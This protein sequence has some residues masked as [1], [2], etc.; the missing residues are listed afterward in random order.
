MV[1]TLKKVSKELV[2]ASKMHKGQSAKIKKYVKKIE[3][4]KN[5]SAR[6]TRKKG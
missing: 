1:K 6:R 5:S 2:K 3:K 4:K